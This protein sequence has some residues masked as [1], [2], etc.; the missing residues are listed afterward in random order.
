MQQQS[1][2]GLG[3]AIVAKMINNMNSQDV[4]MGNKAKKLNEEHKIVE[5]AGHAAAAMLN[6]APEPTSTRKRETTP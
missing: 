6:T 1:S 2:A 3:L 5:R 4:I